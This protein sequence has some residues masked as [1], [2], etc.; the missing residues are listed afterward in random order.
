LLPERAAVVAAAFGV[1]AYATLGELLAHET[2]DAVT[3]ATPDHLHVAPTLEAIAAGCH[4]FCEKPLATSF[5][6]AQQM[7]DA[8]SAR[9]V[10]LAVDYNRRFGF[11]YLQAKA[12]IDAGRIG[13][14][15]RAVIHVTDRTPPPDVAREP[16]VILTTL[17]THHFDLMRYLCGEV[18]SVHARFGRDRG[19]GLVRDVVLSLECSR[20]AIGAIVAGYR[21]DLK[22]T[23]E[24]MDVSG[25]DGE[26][27]IEDV[28]RRVRLVTRDPDWTEACRPNPFEDGDAF[29]DTLKAH[30]CAFIEQIARGLPPPVTGIDGLCG[31]R[32]AEAALESHRRSCAIE[33]RWP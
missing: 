16:H 24:R 19:D 22:R 33:V 11:G 8:A 7:A 30:L 12:L 26:L 4:V 1:R 32:L 15:R 28:T 31:M 9:G 27:V 18:T 10:R 14:V 13:V 29:H 25:A 23:S 21:D 17:L 20:G 5:G 6:E 2:I 3:I